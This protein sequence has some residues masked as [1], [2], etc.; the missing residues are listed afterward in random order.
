MPGIARNRGLSSADLCTLL[1]AYCGDAAGLKRADALALPAV[2]DRNPRVQREREEM[3][4]RAV[5][6]LFVRDSSDS[7]RTLLDR[8]LAET[9]A[10]SSVDFR[11]D[12]LDLL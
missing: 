6:A 2:R 9:N 12:V 1:L 3:R 8:I 4:I 7:I 11:A 5:A 10:T